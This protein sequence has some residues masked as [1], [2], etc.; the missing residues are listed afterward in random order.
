MKTMYAT[1]RYQGDTYHA[2]LFDRTMRPL[3]MKCT[4]T[5]S[6]DEAVKSCV[7]KWKFT[8]PKNLKRAVDDAAAAEMARKFESK[9]PVKKTL[10]VFEVES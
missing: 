9:S 6:D 3:P 7:R 4:C 2:Q 1:T 5:S 8:E 10:W